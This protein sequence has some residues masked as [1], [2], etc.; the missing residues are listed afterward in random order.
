M[1]YQSQFAPAFGTLN[2]E[3]DD[4]K[5]IMR[6]DQQKKWIESAGI[7]ALDDYAVFAE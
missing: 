1:A 2:H 7:C 4:I 3:R 5:P 6:L